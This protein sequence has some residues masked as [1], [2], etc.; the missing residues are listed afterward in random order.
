[1]AQGYQPLLHKMDN[2]T[3]HDVEAFITLEQVRLQNTPPPNMHCT[4]PAKHAVH[5]SKNHFTAGTARLPPS[6]PL[7]HWCR[8]T[9]QSNAILNMMRPCCLNHLLS[10]H[11]ALKGTFSF[12][13]TLMA[14]L[15]TEVL[16]HQKPSQS[17]TWGYHAAK[18]WHLSH[19]AAHYCYIHVIMK[20]IGVNASQT[21]LAINIM[22]SLSWS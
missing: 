14:P 17:R 7:D 13:A 6:F 11:K 16:V 18:A 19:A 2:E 9:T 1:M 22:Q 10:M 12:D 20:A 4:N 5:T 8:L 21:R 3:F 15:D